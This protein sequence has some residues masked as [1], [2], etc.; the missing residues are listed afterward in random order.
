MIIIRVMIIIILLILGAWNW[1]ARSN[2]V[3]GKMEEF[4]RDQ[5]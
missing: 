2:W 4:K 1:S 3:R 5:R